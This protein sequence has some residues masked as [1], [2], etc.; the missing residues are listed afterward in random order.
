MRSIH[1]GKVLVAT[2]VALSL[3]A[4]GSSGIDDILGSSSE[5]P[6]TRHDEVRGTV[7]YVDTTGDCVIELDEARYVERNNLRDDD[8]GLRDGERVTV[9]C[10]DRTVVMHEGR[11]Y[12]PEALERG[13]EIA[14]EVDRSGSRL[15]AG[16]IDVLYDVTG[17]D[18]RRTGFG[19]DLRGTVRSVDR[20]NRTILLER[21]AVYDRELE[22]HESGDR[23]TLL[24]DTDTD[25]MFEGDQY[26]AENL[27]PGDEVE[28]QVV[29]VRGRLIAEE[30]EV[31]SD[32][33][34][35]RY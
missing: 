10:D 11:S 31:I 4:C 6:V 16:R 35:S 26:R 19:G 2:V 32:V 15:I 20:E 14:V 30:I 28:V 18:D 23:V 12:R 13:D 8:Y 22:E 5:P 1:P 34:T 27:E 21:V 3:G 33:R 17:E 29:E 9:Y 24:Y 7:Q 25:V